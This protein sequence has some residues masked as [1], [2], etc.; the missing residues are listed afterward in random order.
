M[1]SFNSEIASM[2]NFFDEALNVDLRKY[3]ANEKLNADDRINNIS[4]EIAHG[5]LSK[6]PRGDHTKDFVLPND[7]N[8]DDFIQAEFKD[9]TVRPLTNLLFSKEV[10]TNLKYATDDD[11][12][13]LLTN[14]YTLCQNMAD[15]AG[16]REKIVS[17]MIKCG[18]YAFDSHSGTVASGALKII[19]FLPDL[20]NASIISAGVALVVLAVVVI[21]TIF[22]ELLLANKEGLGLVINDSDRNITVWEWKNGFDGGEDQSDLFMKHGK[23][24]EFMQDKDEPFDDTAK[25]IQVMKRN[26]LGVFGGLYYMSK[27][28]AALIGVESTM[29]LTIGEEGSSNVDKI[30]FL[31]CCP[32]SQDNRVN[33]LIDTDNSKSPKDVHDSLYDAHKQTVMV[34]NDRIYAIARVNDYSG[35]PSYTILSITQNEQGVR[36][37]DIEDGGIY[38]I[39]CKQAKK[40][41]DINGRSESN[42]AGANIWKPNY[43]D[44]QKFRFVRH[45]KD[46]YRIIALHSG[47]YLEPSSKDKSAQVVQKDYSDS[48]SQ[49]W[50]IEECDSGSLKLINLASLYCMDVKG[51]GT[52]SGTAVI[53]FTKK[54]TEDS[55]QRFCLLT[56]PEIVAVLYIGYDYTGI[57]QTLGIG[58]YTMSSLAIGND[59]LSS[60]KVADGYQVT[61][62]ENSDYTQ[63]IGTYTNDTASFGDKFDNKTSSIIVEKIPE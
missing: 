11:I 18:I 14:I 51:S 63:K 40:N 45:E 50:Q 52:D 9:N 55:N 31:S 23:M 1:K 44:N 54:D 24:V 60:L 15:D 25:K 58:S 38:H 21:T 49:L 32:Y 47:K 62:Y 7:F 48:K 33:L 2:I 57:S 35:S 5:I 46:I 22:I 34:E 30:F 29:R 41:M 59:K 27:R 10:A 20:V 13:K 19:K 42:G 53:L 26:H 12:K 3:Y 4:R 8:V 28:D 39:W 36:K 17:D 6:W 16:N 56:T 61:L 37:D 43:G